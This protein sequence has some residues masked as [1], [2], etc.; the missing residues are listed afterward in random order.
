MYKSNRPKVT[1]PSTQSYKTAQ[2]KPTIPTTPSPPTSGPSSEKGDSGR[3]THIICMDL[4]LK[5][6]SSAQ[7]VCPVIGDVDVQL[8]NEDWVS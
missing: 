8:L 6:M 3:M 1:L 5:M 2:S 7:L 4:E